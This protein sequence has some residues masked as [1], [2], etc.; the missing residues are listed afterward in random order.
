MS[1]L[2]ALPELIGFFSYSREDDQ[3]SRG[4]LS[5]LRDAIQTELS[6]LL[7]RSQ[8]DFRIWQD[9]AAISLGTLWEKQ[10]DQGINQSVFFIPII[11]PRALRSHN[12]SFEFQSFLA[13]EK[14][15]C[16]DDL[17]FPILYIPVPALE[18]DKQWRNDPVLNVVGTRQYLDWRELRHHDPNSTEVRRSIER[19]CRNI[20]NAL[21]KPW[22]SPL[23]RRRREE[24]ETRQRAEEEERRKTA[25]LEA[26]RQ[27]QAERQRHAE[28]EQRARRAEEDARQ[29]A[30]E[31]RRRQKV[32]AEQRALEERAFTAAKRNNTVAAMDAF[33]ATKPAGDLAGEAQ[34][35]KSVLRVREQAYARAMA[36]DDPVVLKSFRDAYRKGVDV[37]H[38][39]ER[40]MALQPPRQFNATRPAIII[41]A[42]LAVL[43]A[44][45]VAVWVETRPAAESKPIAVAMAPLPAVAVPA[46]AAATQQSKSAAPEV[47]A[48]TASAAAPATS[49]SPPPAP[50]PAVAPGPG[51]DEVA[52]PLLQDTNDA[53]ALKRFIAQFPDS[54][55][56]KDAEARLVML[57]AVEASWNLVKD[58]KDPDELRRFVQ[59]F[60]SSPQRAAAEQR[61]ASLI[62]TPPQPVAPPAPDPHELARA[63]QFELQRVGCFTGTVNG[64]FDDDTKA[65]WRRFV[66]LTSLNMPDDLSPD[67]INAVRGINKR[68]CPLACPHGEHVEGNAC[69]ANPSPPPPKRAVRDETRGNERAR[70]APA[71]AAPVYCQ[72]RSSG[73]AVSN[74]SNNCA[75]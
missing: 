21:H 64:A 31:E 12:C 30:A 70:P 53:G 20:S 37:D 43:V 18:D 68:V 8:S 25:Q 55:R 66:K 75:N 58:S 39:R 34:K 67:A 17:V 6:A 4:G 38:V 73:V 44:G 36:S 32:E 23:E 13:R 72:G 3:G 40:L 7:G 48:K 1:S 16:R 35:L 46:P 74:S 14:E 59:T 9:K 65:A 2:A 49:P 24:E 41:P 47:K 22:M 62:A 10:I 56:R 45:A 57:A 42:A 54:P 29:R 19:Y 5:E 63:L 50:A 60:P 51:P 15:L 26:E 52:W 11:T 27:A 33:L 69:V 28:E 61:I 71:P